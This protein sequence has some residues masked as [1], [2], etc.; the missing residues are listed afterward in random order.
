MIKQTIDDGRV[1]PF[2]RYR[3]LQDQL[4]LLAINDCLQCR[5]PIFGDGKFQGGLMGH[6]RPGIRTGKHGP[7]NRSEAGFADQRTHG[8]F[9]EIAQQS[10]RCTINDDGSSLGA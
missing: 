5:V 1:Y 6:D 10:R 3:L 8:G 4:M 7:W 9:Q 2:S